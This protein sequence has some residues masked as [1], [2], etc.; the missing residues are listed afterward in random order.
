MNLKD[1]GSIL[2]IAFVNCFHQYHIDSTLCPLYTIVG[3]E[4]VKESY[5]Q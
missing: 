2:G 1:M 4:R 3:Y 5:K